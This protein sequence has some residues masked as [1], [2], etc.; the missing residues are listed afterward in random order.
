MYRALKFS[1]RAII[2][3]RTTSAR[4]GACGHGFILG[5]NTQEYVKIHDNTEYNS[6]S[7]DVRQCDFN[8]WRYFYQEV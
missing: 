3:T 6:P 2:C 1:L 5:H 4:F 7:S 8:G